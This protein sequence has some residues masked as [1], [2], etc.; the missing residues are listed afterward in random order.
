MNV[1]VI[2]V[3]VYVCNYVCMYVCLYIYIIHCAL[4][5]LHAAPSSWQWLCSFFWVDQIEISYIY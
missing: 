4:Q 5:S 3:C 2:C 1:Y